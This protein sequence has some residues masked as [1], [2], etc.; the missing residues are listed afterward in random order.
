MIVVPDNITMKKVPNIE[1]I[2][3][4]R[5]DKN[6]L[7]VQEDKQLKALAEE[8]KVKYFQL[9][10]NV[11]RENA[12]NLLNYGNYISMLSCTFA[13]FVYLKLFILQI[14]QTLNKDISKLENEIKTIDVTFVTSF[15]SCTY[16]LFLKFLALM[17]LNFDLKKG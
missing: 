3:V 1:G 8:K 16:S 13:N 15:L 14:L 5:K 2:M 4:Y 9:L 12:K 7:Y 17:T 10:Q 11:V 6:K